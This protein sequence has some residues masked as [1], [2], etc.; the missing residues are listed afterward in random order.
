MSMVSDSAAIIFARS[1][2]AITW[3][4]P[5]FFG[6]AAYEAVDHSREP[7]NH[8]RLHALDA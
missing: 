5:D 1:P 3:G 2:V 7:V 4:F 6:G 8:P